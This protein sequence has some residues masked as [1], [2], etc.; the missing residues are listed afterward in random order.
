MSAYNPRC[1]GTVERCNGTFIHKLSN[2][3]I[4][5]IPNGKDFIPFAIFAYNISP[6]ARLKFSPYKI[7]FGYDYT[8]KEDQDTNELDTTDLE[9]YVERIHEIRKEIMKIITAE[10]NKEIDQISKGKSVEDLEIND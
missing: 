10:R 4:T 2:Y 5:I 1:N 6:S 3:A 9:D 8:F 7:V